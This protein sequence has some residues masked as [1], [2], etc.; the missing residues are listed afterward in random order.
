MEGWATKSVK[1]N[2]T[3]RRAPIGIIEYL[4]KNGISNQRRK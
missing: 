3:F 2:V 1:L 4:E